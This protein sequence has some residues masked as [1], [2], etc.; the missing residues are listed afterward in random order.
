MNDLAPVV[1]MARN[2]IKPEVLKNVPA[3]G[4]VTGLFALCAGMAEYRTGNYQAALDDLGEKTESRLGIEPRPTAVFFRAMA[5][6]RLGKTDRARGELDRA[7][8]LM[9]K[10]SS[11]TAPV[12]EPDATIQDW[13]ICQ[14]VRREAEGLIAGQQ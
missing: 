5:F 12:I 9:K 10:V 2:N 8:E 7:Q 1:E 6:Y 13:L 3:A 11:P 4:E 14:I